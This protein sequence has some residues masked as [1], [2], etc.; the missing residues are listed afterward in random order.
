MKISFRLFSVFVL[1]A[2]LFSSCQKELSFDTTGGSGGGN[3]NGGGGNTGGGSGYYIRGK[4]DGVAFN[5]SA[6]TMAKITDL[7]QGIISLS[8]V[9]SAGG[10]NMEGINIGINFANGKSPAVGTYSEDDSS[11]DYSILGVYNPNSTTVVYGAGVFS[12]SAR[13]LVVKILSKTNTEM[14][15]T[16][17]GAFYKTELSSG[18]IGP[19]FILFTEGEFKLKIQ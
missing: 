18:T 13:P 5:L 14:T 7:G 8:L 2:F 3:N 16:F 17:E 19:E 11:L 15:G 9:A 1:F 6:V 4:K 12:P 10:T